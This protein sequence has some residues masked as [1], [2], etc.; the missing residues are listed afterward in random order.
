MRQH[1]GFDNIKEQHQ[2]DQST[3]TA[4]Q[5]QGRSKQSSW[6]GFHRTTTSQGNNKIPFTKKQVIN[7]S[8]LK[9]ID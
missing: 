6:S 7:K 4:S 9:Q 1:N 8:T 3:R 5:N 2:V